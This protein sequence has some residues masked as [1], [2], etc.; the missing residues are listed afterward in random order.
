VA[1]GDHIFHSLIGLLF[2]AGGLLTDRGQSWRRH[3]T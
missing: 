1:W 3:R 2:L